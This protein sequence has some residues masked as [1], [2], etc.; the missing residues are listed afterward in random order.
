MKTKIENY[1]KDWEKKCYHKG[2][3]DEAPLPLEQ[4]NK[5]PSYKKICQAILKNDTSLKSIGF[6]VSKNETYNQLKR[7]E[8]I[9]RGVIKP[10]SQL[11]LFI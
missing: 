1:I 6:N 4:N 3:P 7:A 5:V 2:I 11:K 10:T 9:Q 8:L